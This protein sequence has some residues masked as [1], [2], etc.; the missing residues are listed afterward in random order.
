[1]EQ[2]V[3]WSRG[4]PGGPVWERFLQEGYVVAVADYRGGNWTLAI[5]HWWGRRF[6]L[7]IAG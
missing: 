6:R 1:M 4:D 5:E 7:P 3:G 2:L